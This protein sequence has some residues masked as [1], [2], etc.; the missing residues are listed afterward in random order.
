MSTG[1]VFCLFCVVVL[2]CFLDE[3][4]SAVDEEMECRLYELISSRCDTYISIGK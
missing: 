3:A 1:I 2:Q 4:T